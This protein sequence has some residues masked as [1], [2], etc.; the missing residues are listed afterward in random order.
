MSGTQPTPA[1]GS[2]ATTGFD[3]NR[4]IRQPTTIH[5]LGVVAGAVGA[6]LADVATGNKTLDIAVSLAAYLLVHLGIDDH[7]AASADV[8]ALTTDLISTAQGHSVATTKLL[9]DVAATVQAMQTPAGASTTTT[10][11]ATPATGAVP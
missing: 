11:V 7:S 8:T 10:T 9:G 5:A 1:T 3:F 4:W 2:T 6:A